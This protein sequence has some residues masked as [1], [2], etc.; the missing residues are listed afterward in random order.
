MFSENS[1]A[2]PTKDTGD[3]FKEKTRGKSGFRR[4]TEVKKE[5][6]PLH[7]RKTLGAIANKE[8]RNMV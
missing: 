7:V 1:K 2:L 8:G 5:T 6:A 3:S 4:Y